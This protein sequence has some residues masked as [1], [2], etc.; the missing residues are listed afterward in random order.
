MYM[1]H[2]NYKMPET[3]FLI[4]RTDMSHFLRFTLAIAPVLLLCSCALPAK[5]AGSSAPNSTAQTNSNLSAPPAP[6]KVFQAT[7]DA[8]PGVDSIFDEQ[9][10]ITPAQSIEKGG[11]LLSYSILTVPSQ[12]GDLQRLVLIFRNMQGQHQTIKPDVSLADAQGKRIRHYSKHGFIKASSYLAVK[13]SDSTGKS[14]VKI[15]KKSAKERADWVNTYW[16]KS[17]YKIP[18]HGIALGELVYYCDHCRLPLKL[19]VKLGKQE[20]IFTTKDSLPIA[21]N[22]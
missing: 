6:G 8:Y 11:M 16:L 7:D 14:T 12:V 5:H 21:R 13:N 3:C 19:V 4:Q 22:R 2:K 9:Q 1:Q 17:S 20:F 15:D 18:A 10:E